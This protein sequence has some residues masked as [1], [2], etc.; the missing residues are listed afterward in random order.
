MC[1]ITGQRPVGN[2]I[3]Y[4]STLHKLY[5]FDYLSEI[6]KSLNSKMFVASKV[7]GKKE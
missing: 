1:L 3:L 2:I 4:I 7:L 5:A 6:Q